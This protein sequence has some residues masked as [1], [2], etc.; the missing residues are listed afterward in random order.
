MVELRKGKNHRSL[1]ILQFDYSIARESFVHCASFST[2][3][4]VSQMS[5]HGGRHQQFLQE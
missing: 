1:V 5:S 4:S 3:I 2:E